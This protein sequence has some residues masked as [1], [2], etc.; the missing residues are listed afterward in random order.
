MKFKSKINNNLLSLNVGVT[1]L[2]MGAYGI[3]SNDFPFKSMKM[4]ENITEEVKLHLV[5]IT[6]VFLGLAYIL[7]TLF[8]KLKLKQLIIILIA[9]FWAFT[10]YELTQKLI[11]GQ[12]NYTVML[13]YGYLLVI[14]LE[15]REGEF[16]DHGKYK[17][18]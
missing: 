9:M 18:N 2:L 3:Y 17:S 12:E 7:S 11:H 13:A 14:L 10:C 1:L 8:N 16:L 6:M 5:T 15:A 4:P